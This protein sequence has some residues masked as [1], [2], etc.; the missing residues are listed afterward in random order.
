MSVAEQ[1][2]EAVIRWRAECLYEAGL[3]EN[4]IDLAHILATRLD[5]NLHKVCDALEAGAT[6]QQIALIFL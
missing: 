6:P 3:R 5:I 1:E 2:F 4:D